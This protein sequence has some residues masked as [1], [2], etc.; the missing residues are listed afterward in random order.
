MKVVRVF[1]FLLFFPVLVSAGTLKGIVR[2]LDGKPVDAAMVAVEGYRA[3]TTGADGRFALEVPAGTYTLAVTRSGFQATAIKAGTETDIE[4]TLRPGL[5]ENIVV[6]GIRAE[7]QTPVTKSDIERATIERDYYGQ[8]VPLLLRDTPSI[9]AYTES[10]VGGSGYSYITLRGIS[11]TRINFTLDG[12]PLADSEDMGTYFA[13]FP[14]L[15]RSLQSIQVQRGVGTSTV[16]S[17]AFGGSINFESIALAPAP[18]TSA[19]IGAGSF[20]AK[21]ATVGYQSGALPGGY[22]FY[23]RLSDDQSNGFRESSGFRGHNLFVSAAK[24]NEDSQLKLTGFTAH[25]WTQQSFYAADAETLATNLRANPLS[26]QDRDSFGYDLAQLQYL[27]AISPQTNMTASAFYQRGYGWY[28][29]SGDQYGLDGMLIGSMVTLSTTRGPWTA[30]Y[31]LHFNQFQRTH[32]LDS[33]GAREYSNY[34]T[35][36]EANAFAKLRYDDGRWHLYSDAQVRTTNFHYHGDV[37]IAPIRWTFFNPKLGARYDL[38]AN[39]SVYG[40]AGMSTR[41]PTRN[42]LFQGEDNASFAHDLH[43]V[44][45]ERVIDLEAGWDTHQGPLTVSANVYAMEFRH[46]I[47]S[48]GELSDIGLLL[49][50]NVDRSYRRGIEMEYGWQA[51]PALHLRGNASISRNRIHSWTQFYDVYDAAGNITGSQPITYHGVN[52]VLTPTMLVNQSIDYAASRSLTL[53]VTG[54]H[55]GRSYLDNTNNGSFVAPAFT[56]MD[57][58]AAFRLSR[59]ITVRLQINNALNEK[60]VYPSGYSYLFLTPEKTISGTSYYYPQATRN[61]VITVEWRK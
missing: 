16:G 39:S 47:A 6:S 54:R 4:V 49:R 15:A 53:G 51:T 37:T 61:A 27:R 38:T 2:G 26:P 52:P 13:D 60:R 17:P 58:N 33:G 31:G 42:D 56:T 40:S 23:T 44:K 10:G 57:A 43:A 1:V 30:N 59:E 55:V 46:E 18:S 8:D 12:V 3:V 48:T 36:G 7:A 50:R 14:D 9:D 28:R 20:G 11:P 19:T 35:K 41:E 34:G 21:N 25:E 32:T 22:S 5:A 29:L 45:P 24:Q